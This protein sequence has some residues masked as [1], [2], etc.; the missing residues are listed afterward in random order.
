M[1]VEGIEFRG[2]KCF[3]K[4][5]WAG[6][7]CF[8]QFNVIVGRNNAGKSQLLDLARVA[9]EGDLKKH[10]FD[11]ILCRNACLEEADL[12]SAFPDH[13]AGGGLAGNHWS[14][15]GAHLVG[16]TVQILVSSGAVDMTAS[17]GEL[18]RG[19]QP[20]RY[21]PAEVEHLVRARRQKVNAAVASCGIRSRLA[22]LSFRRLLADRDIRPEA[23][24]ATRAEVSPSGRGATN[25]IRRV[26]QSAGTQFDRNLI[27]KDLRD[28][29]NYIF[30]EDG[31]FSD[32]VIRQ[33]EEAKNQP[34]E[35]YLEE[36]HK[37]LVKLSDSGSGLKT[38]LLV[39][40]N[41]LVAPVFTQGKP[42]GFGC[43][44]AFEELENN[45][46][47]S[48][49]RRLLRFLCAR[50][51]ETNSVLFLTTHSN[52]V[53]DFFAG[54]GDTEVVHVT[55]DGK[56]AHTSQISKHFDRLSVIADLGARASDLLQANGIVW[57]EGPSDRIYLN[58]WIELA[59]DGD[60]KEGRD[61]QIACY[62]GALLGRTQLKSPDEA[63]E[64]LV[65]LIAVNPNIVLVADRDHPDGDLKPRVQRI[66]DEAKITGTL[67]WVTKGRE[68]ENYLPA[69]AL[70]SALGLKLSNDPEA[71][72]WFFPRSRRSRSTRTALPYLAIAGIVTVPDKVHMALQ[73]APHLSLDNMKPR[74]DW[75]AQIQPIVELIRSWRRA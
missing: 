41:T 67:V 20:G 19:V 10:P 74:L 53:L 3:D 36:E 32:I 72:E 34:W 5:S 45:L 14:D 11:A 43:S 35:V 29:L 48:V 15:H 55:H 57:V 2:H 37:G 13:P 73:V 39:L 70:S 59:S 6:F 54:E 71:K 28:A 1:L 23:A 51:R 8:R 75:N 64:E 21:S 30:A 50:V 44:F 62:G 22:G 68:I 46:H 38:V 69:E 27:R 42:P 56:S 12:K 60:L 31:H 17:D 40:L 24:D 47:P 61:Y 26:L 52:V 25:L 9:C 49:L 33:D 7:A 65:N 63:N 4:S 18:R 58:R 66:V 16:A